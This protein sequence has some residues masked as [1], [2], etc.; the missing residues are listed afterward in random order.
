MQRLEE[1]LEKLDEDM[2]ANATNSAKL[3]ELL[4]TKKKVG[5]AL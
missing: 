5:A 1:A 3:G 2:A 4:G